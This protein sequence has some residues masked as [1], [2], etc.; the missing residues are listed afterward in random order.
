[1]LCSEGKYRQ[2]IQTNKRQRSPRGSRSQSICAS[3]VRFSFASKDVGIRFGVDFPACQLAE[4]GVDVIPLF[5]YWAGLAE[6]CAH[7]LASMNQ[8]SMRYASLHRAHEWN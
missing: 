7:G 8:H 2:S 4:R 1:M 5:D 6:L 3:G